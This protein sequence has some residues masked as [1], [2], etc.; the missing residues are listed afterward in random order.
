MNLSIIIISKKVDAGLINTVDDW[1]GQDYKSKEII[2]VTPDNKPINKKVII[3]K[4]LKKGPSVA[5]N[6]GLKKARGKYIIFRDSDEY[7]SVKN[8]KKLLSYAMKI[9]NKKNADTGHF[10]SY[11]FKSGNFLRDAINIKD[12]M[13]TDNINILWPIIIKKNLIKKGFNE[14]LEYGE[15]KEF[16]P[17]IKKKKSVFINMPIMQ[18]SAISNFRLFFNRYR[19]YGR[20][21][22]KYIKKTNDYNV[23]LIMFASVIFIFSLLLSFKYNYFIIYN[24]CFI[25]YYYIKKINMIKYCIKKKIIFEFLMYPFITVISE[26]IMLIFFLNTKNHL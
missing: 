15:D 2:V 19:W 7:S 9:I 5:R 10:L 16:Y 12:T 21:I 13:I 11:P 26:I 20:T 22:K 14:E 25:F 24:L 18:D 3:I 23:L 4:D 6:L 17:R 1:L 8:S